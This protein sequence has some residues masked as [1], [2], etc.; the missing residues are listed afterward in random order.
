MTK[1]ELLEAINTLFEDEHLKANIENCK[2]FEEFG[3]NRLIKAVDSSLK[4]TPDGIIRN[5]IKQE[6]LFRKNA[7]QYDD[8]TLLAIMR[9]R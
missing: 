1:K 7:E 8:L 9:T 3:R 2:H 4:K 5:V 6:R